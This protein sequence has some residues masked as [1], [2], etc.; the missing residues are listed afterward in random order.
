M[1]GLS[2]CL[3]FW[4]F[5]VWICGFWF[6][7]AGSC[8][9]QLVFGGW[10]LGVIWLDSSVFG[11]FVVL[12]FACFSCVCFLILFWFWCVSWF[13]SFMLVGCR[14]KFG[15]W[16]WF[17]IVCGLVILV[18]GWL[19]GLLFGYDCGLMLW[20]CFLG[21][22]ICWLFGYCRFCLLFIVWDYLFGVF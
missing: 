14:V 15:F 6:W 10:F 5:V 4:E 17:L 8:G 2:W 3:C 18:L 1:V 13:G 22:L 11:G 12:D 9:V 19:V 7:F 20:F 16:C 21:F